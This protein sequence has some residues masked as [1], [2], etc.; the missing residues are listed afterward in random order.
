RAARPYRH[1]ILC[2][3]AQTTLL[4]RAAIAQRGKHL[5]YFTIIWNSLEGLVAITAGA[6][7]GSISLVGFGIDSLIEVTSGVTLLW[8]MA[9]DANERRRERVEEI[10]LRIVGVCFVA[11]AAF[12]SYDP[13]STLIRPQGSGL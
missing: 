8:R 11:L 13:V 4:D 2:T 6:V 1:S 3:M 10:S 7:A 9:S 5:E 12:V